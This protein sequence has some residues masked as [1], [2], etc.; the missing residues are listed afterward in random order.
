M[1][2]VEIYKKP[3]EPDPPEES[4]LAEESQDEDKIESPVLDMYGDADEETC[5]RCGNPVWS[6]FRYCPLCGEKLE[7]D[8]EPDE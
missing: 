6:T 4:E 8:D 2:T 7:I 3:K 5:P 1:K